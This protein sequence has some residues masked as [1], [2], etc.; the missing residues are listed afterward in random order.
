MKGLRL[1][2]RIRGA[3][4]TLKDLLFN[5]DRLTVVSYTLLS[6]E[7]VL[8]VFIINK[9]N[10]TEID[11]QSYMQEV[12]GVLNGTTDYALLKGDTGPLVYPAGFVYIFSALYFVT[13]QG[14]NVRLAQYIF[15][16]M[17]LL[18][19]HV[20]FRLY[21]K[22]RRVPPY[23]LVLMSASSYRIH[24]IFVLRLFNDGVAML[25]L[26]VALALFTR[27]YW[28]LGCFMYSVAVSVKMNILLFAPALLFILL[29]TN[30]YMK[31]LL[32]LGVCG[33]VQLVAALP[34]LVA[35]YRSY[36]MRSFDLGRV[37]EYRWTVNWRCIP[38]WL[39]LDRTFH[40]TLLSLHVVVLLC[41]L[42]KFIRLLIWGLLE[43]SWNTYPSTVFSSLILHACHLTVLSC[44]WFL[45]PRK[46]RLILK[47]K[48]E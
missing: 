3:T 20:V 43:M 15:A 31:T 7:L 41:F 21:T 35:N 10:Y 27:K 24:S 13:K 6:I 40:I 38:E 2:S 29:S 4:S 25:I 11:W 23:V 30:G 14:H 34:F 42:P 46:T 16:G 12:E 36:L 8:N 18:L 33:I 39:F 45:W 22:T 47:S 17:Y 5:P 48:K 9:V 26:Y 19:L 1:K 37:F 32:N 28:V 44:L